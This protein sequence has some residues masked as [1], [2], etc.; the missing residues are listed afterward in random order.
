RISKISKIDIQVFKS[1]THAPHANA[2]TTS[3]VTGRNSKLV[4]I[5]PNASDGGLLCRWGS[6]G[7]Q[8]LDR[9]NK[10]LEKPVRLKPSWPNNEDMAT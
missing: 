8:E 3:S 9:F 1:T 7:P 4:T 10:L 2:N 6:F 5:T